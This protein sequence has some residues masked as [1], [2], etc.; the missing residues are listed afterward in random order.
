M[1][2]YIESDRYLEDNLPWI[3]H[4]V[5]VIKCQLNKVSEYLADKTD[6]DA[7]ELRN[8]VELIDSQLEDVSKSLNIILSK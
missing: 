6:N 3:A 8:A 4:S 1:R 2:N 5:E 7:D